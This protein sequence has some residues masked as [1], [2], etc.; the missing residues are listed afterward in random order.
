MEFPLQMMRGTDTSSLNLH[1]EQQVIVVKV[2]ID[3]FA[4]PFLEPMVL[5]LIS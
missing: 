4:S 2:L 1:Y 3:A 5:T